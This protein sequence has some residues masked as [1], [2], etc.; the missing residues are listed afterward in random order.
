MSVPDWPNTYGYNMFYFPFSQWVGGIFWEHSHRLMASL[1]GLMTLTLTIWSHGRSGRSL[2]R[3]VILPLSILLTILVLINAENNTL[4]HA[5]ITGMT[6]IIALFASFFWPRMKPASKWIRK[7]CWM[8]LLMVIGQGLLGGLRVT[9]YK[10]EIG[11]IHAT[12]AQLFLVLMVAITFVSSKRWI[13]WKAASRDKV[14]VPSLFSWMMAAL[15]AFVVCQLIL[16]AFMRHEHAGLAVT[17]FPLAYDQY[18]WPPTHAEFVNQLNV[19]R[20]DHRDF[21]PVTALHIH[22]HMLHRS[23]ALILF[24]AGSFF[25]GWTLK[26]L[27]RHHLLGRLSILWFSLLCLQAFLGIATVWSNKAADIATIHVLIGALTLALGSF[28]V[29]AA[30][31]SVFLAKEV[32]AMR[33]REMPS[34]LIPTPEVAVAK[35]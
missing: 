24:I 9:L 18:F 33:H 31:R 13:G 25:V 17:G 27:G 21:N 7:L 34:D 1:V 12:L 35:G 32:N 10:D 3:Y 29:L 16:G 26:Y 23:M 30:R 19:D 28:M 14:A 20:M 11:I 22:V 2:L 4:Q 8:A 15:C 6:G 5:S